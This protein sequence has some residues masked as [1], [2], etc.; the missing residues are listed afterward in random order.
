MANPQTPRSRAEFKVCFSATG[1]SPLASAVDPNLQERTTVGVTS[2]PGKPATGVFQIEQSHSNY[3]TGT[4]TDTYAVD[5]NG[6]RM[7]CM[8]RGTVSMH[9]RVQSSA[10]RSKP[11]PSGHACVRNDSCRGHE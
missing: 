5:M 2:E 3:G 9:P 6:G 8:S 1:D 4:V 10:T 7:W 11:R